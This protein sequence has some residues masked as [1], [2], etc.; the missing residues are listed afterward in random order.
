MG[1]FTS[2]AARWIWRSSVASPADKVRSGCGRGDGG[3]ALA[4]VRREGGGE[5]E[6]NSNWR[7]FVGM[8]AR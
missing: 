5:A 7:L 8:S 3:A 6:R 4:V 1:E 2:R